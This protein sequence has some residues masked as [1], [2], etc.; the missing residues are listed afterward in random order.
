MKMCNGYEMSQVP[1]GSLW[2]M[3]Y[4]LC[5]KWRHYGH[6]QEKQLKV[7]I[8]E[9]IPAKVHM[10]DIVEV[11]TKD[12]V[13]V[14]MAEV[15]VQVHILE[16]KILVMVHMVDIVDGFY[17]GGHIGGYD[18]YVEKESMVRKC[19]IEKVWCKGVYERLGD[20]KL[21]TKTKVVKKKVAIEN[22][23]VENSC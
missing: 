16:E 17:G 19:M 7:D 6:I 1:V 8:V 4:S 21:V 11:A 2:F 22:L 12:I 3:V 23:M 14:V 13:Q 18:E 10:K 15:I 20:E 5:F 9:S